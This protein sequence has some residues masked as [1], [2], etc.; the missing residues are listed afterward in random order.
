MAS[1]NKDKSIQ[2]S[3]V[4]SLLTRSLELGIQ[5]KFFRKGE[6]ILE[7]GSNNDS[8]HVILE[9]EAELVRKNARGEWLQ[10]DRLSSGNFIGLISFWTEGQSFS[11]SRALGDLTCVVMK[12]ERFQKL[13]D[14]DREF[15]H[16]IQDLIISNLTQRYR[17][18]ALLNVEVAEL[19]RDLEIERNHLKET[20]ED[21]EATRTRMVHQEKLATM[22]QLLAGIAHEINNPSSALL[23][24]V[25]SLR[26]TLP[27]LF[28]AG[29]SLATLSLE[30]S[31]LDRGLEADFCSSQV[32][33]ERMEALRSAFPTIKRSMLRRLAQMEESVHELIA[34][35]LKHADK[36]GDTS[37]LE[38]LV[39]C[40]ELGVFL[41]SIDAS[42]NRITSLVTSLK[43][44]GR[45]D[46]G[47]RMEMDLCDCLR[48]TLM[49]LNNRLKHF[50]L[51]VESSSLP[52]VYCHPGEINQILTN[53]LVNACDATPENFEIR[54]CCG[55]DEIWSWIQVSDRGCGIPP[56]MLDRIFD[57]NVT[58]KN[59][60]GEFG[61]GL[62]LA[63]SRDIAHKHSGTLTAR[64][65]EGGGAEFLL[66][67]PI[68]KN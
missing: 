40:F 34:K 8:L 23:R 50:E 41:R 61:L 38:H 21:L 27:G 49:V 22:G 54:I 24:S 60:S 51:V 59:N 63:I 46:S 67:L 17:R 57:A 28:D 15:N 68:S 25:S 37:R 32:V 39:S 35:D 55:H 26:K 45:T 14:D 42:A 64:N 4:G 44:Y 5:T 12:R 11:G 10:V 9:G 53:L 1:S 65:R 43:N 2:I 31:L 16:I 19:S 29:G 20:I 18:M 33:R 48:D 13:M 7:Q 47:E 62:G 66:K 30:K 52:S 6:T 36:K 58:S 3:A 56:D